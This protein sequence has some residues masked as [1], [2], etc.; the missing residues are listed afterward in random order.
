MADGE[1]SVLIVDDHDETRRNISKLLQFESDINVV[2][3]VQSAKAGIQEAIELNPD[4]VLMD[5]NMPDVD[6]IKATEAIREKVPTT[7]IVIL[8]VQGDANYMRRAMLAGARD[9]LTKPAKSDELVTVIRRAGEKAKEEK[10]KNVFASRNQGVGQQRLGGTT[11]QLTSLGKIIS[12]YSPKGGVGKTTLAVNLAVTLHNEDTPA[13]VVDTDLQF[14]DVAV[15]LNERSKNSLVDLT[16]LVE[17][18][19]PEIVDEV[20]IHHKGS[21][22]DILSAP[23]H[24]EDAEKA[25]G[26]EVVKVLEYLKHLYSYVILDTDQG[27]SDITL[28]VLDVSDLIILITVQDIP[29]IINT[30][31]MLNLMNTLGISQERVMLVLNRFDKEVAI[32]PGKISKNLNKDISVVLPRDDEVVILSVNKGVPFMLGPGK[33]KDIAKTILELA[34][35]SREKLKSLE[36]SRLEEE[37]G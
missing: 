30:R 24:P 13:I 34:G 29:S 9:F 12:V 27:L 17:Q 25:T 19:D 35:K 1:Y 7:Q 11:T 37:A 23:P 4:V 10:Q 20:V 36:G 31:V 22:V 2:G 8:S 21:G 15:F 6:G 3:T 33:S 28:D 26:R 5:I 18:L 16:P 14:G 32:T